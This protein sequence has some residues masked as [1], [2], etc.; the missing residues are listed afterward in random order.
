MNAN[1]NTE[2]NFNPT[3]SS[4]SNSEL[5]LAQTTSLSSSGTHAGSSTMPTST[6]LTWSA[7][8]EGS[9]IQLDLGQLKSICSLK[10]AFTNGDESISFFNIQTSADGVH[11]LDHGPFQNTGLV[12]S[13]E[14]YISYSPVTARFVK[15][16]FQG[17]TQSDSYNIS[18]IK[19]LGNG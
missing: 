17:S 2:D 3:R 15:L 10:I 12:S 14:Q 8:G 13:L 1:I 4:D 18:N 7:T 6:P 19:V 5:N 9:W 11:F 16:M